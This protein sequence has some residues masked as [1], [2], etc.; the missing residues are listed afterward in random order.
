MNTMLFIYQLASLERNVKERGNKVSIGAAAASDRSDFLSRPASSST[1]LILVDKER[2]LTR[3]LCSTATRVLNREPLPH[4]R[5]D[6]TYIEHS[7]LP[8]EAAPT[9]ATVPAPC[10]VHQCNISPPLSY[11][12]PFFL[13]AALALLRQVLASEPLAKMGVF[14]PF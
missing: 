3:H 5:G 6:H 7:L 9:S 4:L 10:E 13:A 11:F 14:Q 12:S 8:P 2:L 1:Q